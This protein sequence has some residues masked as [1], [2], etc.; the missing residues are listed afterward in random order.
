M[1]AYAN[2]YTRTLHNSDKT[3]HGFENHELQEFTKYET[4]NLND[5]MTVKNLISSLVWWCMS[6]IPAW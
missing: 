5:P 3:E 6:I 2:N 1:Y 4:K